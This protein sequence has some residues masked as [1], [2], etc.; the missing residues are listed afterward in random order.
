MKLD[1]KI[2]TIVL[3]G[4]QALASWLWDKASGDDSA[5]RKRAIDAIKRRAL[6]AGIDAALAEAKMLAAAAGLM[7]AFDDLG[8]SAAQVMRAFDVFE[9]SGSIPKLPLLGEVEIVE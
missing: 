4:A 5:D 8:D 6:Q 7:L 3:D 2:A 9:V 1:P